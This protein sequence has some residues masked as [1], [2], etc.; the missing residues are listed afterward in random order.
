MSMKMKG[1][2]VVVKADGQDCL[3]DDFKAL[4]ISSREGEEKEVSEVLGRTT[5][6]GRGLCVAS[7]SW[8]AR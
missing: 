2:T 6:A 5:V 7:L 8:H 3:L 4:L 1:K